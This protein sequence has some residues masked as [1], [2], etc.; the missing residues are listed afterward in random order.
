[1]T[2][3]YLFAAA[4]V[5]CGSTKGFCGKKISAFTSTVGRAA[6]AN[7]VRMLLCIAVGIVVALV[8]AGL[9][10]LVASPYVLLISL[11]S[12]A[13]NAIFVI[14]WLF[15]VQRGAYMLVDVFLT[16]GTALPILLSYFVYGE[17]IGGTRVIGFFVLVG[18]TLCL[19]SYSSREKQK[20][21]PLDLLPILL[22][23]IT[24]GLVGFS[25]KM[26]VHAGTTD[27]LATFNLYT[28]AF[29]GA[30]LA[31]FFICLRARAPRSQEG[32]S[33]MPPVTYLYIAVMALCLFAGSYFSTLAARHLDAVILFPLSQGSNL[34]LATLM[35]SVFFGEKIRWRLIFGLLLAF[36]G[37]LIMNL[38]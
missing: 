21:R 31:L 33:P 9:T 13:S 38:L 6:Y 18:A 27:S 25:Q 20:I 36:V 28:Y 37:L 16:L 14:S 15:A 8:S 10:A 4:A 3:G 11:L 23:G 24:H 12:G 35:A 2:F 30:L 5:L 1:M 7:L 26:F 19:M 34:I 22:A 32:I 29:A 17:K